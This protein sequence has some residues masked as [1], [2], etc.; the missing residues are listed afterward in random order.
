MRT[1]WESRFA[2]RTQRMQGSAIRE[3]LKI[4]SI[5]GIIS[6]G[7]GLPA[8]DVFPVKE[9][10][11]ACA[12]VF[13]DP[14][15]A[16]KALQYSSSEGHLPLR[17]MIARHF[18]R[19]GT[20]ITADNVLITSG[21]Q[22]ALDVIGKVFI[23][24]GDHILVE[25]PT[26]LG[27]LQAWDAYGAEYIT[28]PSDENGLITDELEDALRMGPKFMYVL[29]NFQ[30]PTGVTIPLERRKRIVELADQYGVPIV[31]DDPYGQLRYE[32]E[33][34]PS[35]GVLDDITRR[36]QSNPITGI[37]I[38]LST[39]SKTLAPGLRLAWIIAPVNV[40]NKFVQAKQG[41]DLHS[42]T[43]NQYIAYEV[44]SGGFIDRHVKLIR[45]VYSERRNTM[46]D[47]L[48][49]HMPE[50]VKWT[51][52]QGGLF[53]WVTLPENV[54][55]ADVF[56]KAVQE[57][58]AFVIGSPFHPKGGGKNTLRLNFS[59]EKPEVIN[60]GIARL[61]RVLKRELA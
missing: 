40:I 10:A 33:H 35:I 59:C 48:E 23:N 43:M 38:Y 19:Y 9:F 39:F 45:E 7:G 42:A 27:A 54:D 6:F 11:E 47:A 34:L 1:P 53:L 61:G 55:A 56:T 12:R 37:A 18:N 51:H 52:P 8:P 5:P 30:N 32:G 14:E 21:S 36:E 60:E 26:Y 2:Q 4:T 41:M 17:E 49:E 31:E 22:Q 28:V 24:P 20:T 50:G 16:K 13:D 44:A 57:K 15:K 58:V 25:S 3:L 29:P 46:L